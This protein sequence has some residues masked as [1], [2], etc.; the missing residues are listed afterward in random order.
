MESR[1]GGLDEK[2]G[3]REFLTRLS[4][5]LGGLATM[6]AGV[7]VLGL[8]LGP[9]VRKSPE[10]WRSVGPVSRFR[11]GET[12][13]AVFEDPSREGWAGVTAKTGVW[14]RKVSITGT[15]G[16]PPAPRSYLYDTTR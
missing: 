11:L 7:P 15:A 8:I 2:P 9:V 1:T 5:G 3:R 6:L 12:V 16:L 10:V 14:L 13:E 4:V